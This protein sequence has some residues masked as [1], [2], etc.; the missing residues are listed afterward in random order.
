MILANI[1]RAIH[2]LIIITMLVI[3]FIGTEAMLKNYLFVTLFIFYHWSIN[4]DTCALTELE[5][6]LRNCKKEES[7]MQ[8]IIGPI[9]NL[10]DDILGKIMKT[11]MLLLNYYVM[12]KLN[13]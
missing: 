4:N 7:F 11:F 1:I 12:Y 13:V 8:Q 2:L 3:P 10:S 6:K 9:Y 5:K